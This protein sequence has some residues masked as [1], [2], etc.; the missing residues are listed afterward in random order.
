MID[1][2]DGLLIDST[3]LLEESGKGA[4]IWEDRIPLSRLFQK[5]ALSYAKDP[6][7]LALSGGEDYELL[8]TAPPK[9]RGRVSSLAFLHRIPITRIGEILTPKRGSGSSGGMGKN[10]LQRIWVSTIS[11]LRVSV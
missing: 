10:T 6:Y 11:G 1:V 7:S 3:H 8:F 4:R 2:S 9:M 5:Y